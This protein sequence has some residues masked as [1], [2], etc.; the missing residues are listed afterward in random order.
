[1]SGLARVRGPE[2]MARRT[3]QP[4]RRD[5]RLVGR[6]GEVALWRPFKRRDVGRYLLAAERYE[7]ATKKPGARYGAL[8]VH[9]PRV[10]RELLRIIDFATGRLEPAI[11]TLMTRLKLSR[12]AVVRALAG[13]KAARFL[14]WVRRLEPVEGARGVRGPQVKQATNAYG[15]LPLPTAAE[16]LLVG[17]PEPADVVQRR[18][19]MVAQLRGMEAD[20][21][22]HAVEGTALGRALARADA[23]FSGQSASPPSG[24]NPA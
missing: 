4:V 22:R 12:T 3:W 5:S 21:K 6:A 14:D 13:L 1:M 7:M 20:A 17:A 24:Q 15:I 23:A 18:A 16:A 11:A 9:G 19:E 2:T 8:G 10:L